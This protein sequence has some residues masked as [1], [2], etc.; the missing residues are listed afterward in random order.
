MAARLILSRKGF[1]SAAG[2]GYSPYDPKTG[3]YI[4]LHIPETVRNHGQRYADLKLKPG[5]LAGIDA[6]DLM[7]VVTNSPYAYGSGA[8]AAVK[9]Q[10]HFDPWLGS[11]PW[12]VNT[13]ETCGALGQRYAAQRHL[14]NMDV[15]PGSIF[16]F[17]SRFIE[18]G[19]KRHWRSGFHAIFGWL[20]VGAIVCDRRD[21]PEG[22]R[23]HPH[24]NDVF[25]P[26][27]AI[28]L[29]ADRLF[30]GFDIPGA[31][32]FPTPAACQV[33]SY[34]DLSVTPRVWALPR[35]FMDQK[36][37][38]FPKTPE[39]WRVQ[40][41]TCYVKSPARGQEFVTDLSEPA[42]AWVRSLFGV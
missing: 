20:R 21:L 18:P 27:N 35:F 37:S 10:V 28:Y 12:L 38:Y 41:N 5:Y 11:C 8:R 22:L 26:G 29:A 16:L 15:G 25:G 6:S 40:G 19:K 33:L 4:L 32:Y 31:G 17:L 36:P 7:E 2:H 1:D 24:Y 3:R 34:D 14:R 9:G 42:I 30:D 39:E 23:A 13:P